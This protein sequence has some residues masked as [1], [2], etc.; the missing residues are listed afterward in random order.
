MD[1]KKDR[2]SIG[3]VHKIEDSK[4][5]KVILQIIEHPQEWDSTTEIN[6]QSK[7]EPEKWITRDLLVVRTDQQFPEI[8]AREKKYEPAP[9]NNRECLQGKKT[10]NKD[11]VTNKKDGEH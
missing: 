1:A 9:K 3:E 6:N 7:A 2:K 10:L 4:F 11:G 5:K 8:Q